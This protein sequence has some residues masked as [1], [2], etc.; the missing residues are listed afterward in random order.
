MK[1]IFLGL[2][3]ILTFTLVSCSS[4]SPKAVAQKFLEHFWHMEYKDAK[5]YSTDVT[6]DMLDMLEQVSTIMPDSAKQNA[7]KIKVDIKDVKENGDKAVVS[8]TTS[9][10]PEEKQLNM[11]KQN[12]K[13]L[14]NLT[15]NDNLGDEPDNTAAPEVDSAAADP[16]VGR[17]EADAAAEGDTAKNKQ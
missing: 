12:G 17:N 3:A 13:W 10:M 11:V 15:K 2:A 5:E 1:K 8:F 16:N 7:K 14:V 4:N 9:E 6:K